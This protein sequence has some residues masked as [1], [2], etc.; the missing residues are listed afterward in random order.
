MKNILLLTLSVWVC[1]LHAQSILS[2]KITVSFTNIKT[3]EA[4]RLI[5]KS[6]GIHFAYN[7]D[8]FN[9]DSSISAA[10]DNIEL[11]A[12]LDYI[13]GK[14]YA[15]R[16]KGKYIIIKSTSEIQSKNEKYIYTISGYI[17]D[18]NTGET[19][20]FASIYDSATLNATLSNESGFYS[21]NIEKKP[22]EIAQI[23]ISKE[24]YRDTFVMIK[25]ADSRILSVELNKIQ[26]PNEA[27]GA[28]SGKQNLDNN[29]VV[30]L[31]TNAKLRLQSL[32]LKKGF[33]RSSQ[34]S[35][36]PYLGTNGALSGSITNDYSLNILGGYSGGVRKLELGGIFNIDRDT[37]SGAQFAGVYNLTAGPF[38]G[39]Q[40]AGVLNNHF[41][42]F[43][44]AQFAG[45]ANTCSGTFSGIQG[46]GVVNFSKKE[47]KG[48]QVAGLVNYANIVHGA[49]ISGFINTASKVR[50]TQIAGFVNTAKTVKG[51]QIGFI[52]V[53]DTV[54]GVQLGFLSF[55]KS[56]VHQVEFS[57]TDVLRYNATFRTG[58]K[59]F[60]N[61]LQLGYHPMEN[62]AISAGYGVGS[63]LK[64]SKLSSLNFELT[65]HA[66]YLGLWDDIN[67]LYRFSI[68]HEFVLL[69]TIS[70]VAGPDF[71]FYYS[72]GLGSPLPG[73]KDPI[74][75]INPIYNINF[76]NGRSGKAWI[77]FHLGIGLN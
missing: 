45:V 42:Q 59:H 55:C 27:V 36:L 37:S 10:F 11:H 35:F 70:I 47:L 33:R 71:N 1:S 19:L 62:E 69:K 53:A 12:V 32:N 2:Q 18:S 30:N 60:Y 26:N 58:S 76:N 15:Y 3:D 51:T 50:G 68:H 4:L 14:N 6:T 20:A 73:Y 5:E 17:R 54:K 38:K 56:G 28:D 22:Q 31:L 67:S 65:G 9:N 74:S 64:I 44:G 29:P 75:Y 41:S 61:I 46:A 23:G 48:T 34:I 24:N 13:I 77:G 16:E 21:L 25:P 57:Y 49:Q 43:G 66:F 63:K 7:A 8:I 39:A 72:N 52:N 40:F